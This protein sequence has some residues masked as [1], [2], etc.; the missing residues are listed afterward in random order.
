[1][2]AQERYKIALNILAR[3]GING[4]L[5]GEFAKA[6]S[7]LHGMDSMSAIQP[8]IPQTPIPQ[9]NVAET[10][11]H[12]QNRQWNNRQ[13]RFLKKKRLKV[14]MIIFNMPGQRELYNQ[15]VE[16]RDLIDSSLDS[17]ESIEILS[18]FVV[19]R[20]RAV[21]IRSFGLSKS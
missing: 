8:T 1:M 19:S 7:V 20:L 10:P 2:T 5:Q 6:M 12:R 11:I 13:N 3:V 9:E 4:D 14:V 15:L 18:C 21:T 16:A 17:I